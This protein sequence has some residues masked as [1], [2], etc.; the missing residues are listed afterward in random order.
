MRLTR[1]TTLYP[2]AA[3]DTVT[4]LI[5]IGI[6]LGVL[7]IDGSESDRR[8]LRNC[9]PDEDATSSPVSGAY[10]GAESA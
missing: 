1:R 5:C 9:R 4:A 2:A 8:S 10:T 6:G 7:D 3:I